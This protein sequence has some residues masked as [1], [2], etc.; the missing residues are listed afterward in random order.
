MDAY[1]E[2]RQQ[3]RVKRDK[4]IQAA[5]NECNVAL[6]RIAALQT[7]IADESRPAIGQP[8]RT[9][10]RS[11]TEILR[12]ALPKDKPFTVA[13]L[14]QVM[15]DSPATCKYKATS[16][17]SQFRV[18]D[19]GG[20]IRKVGRRNGQILWVRADAEIESSPFSALTLCEIAE[21]LI[22]EHGPL[23]VPEMVAYMRDRGYRPDQSGRY[24]GSLMRQALLRVNGR[25]VKDVS[26]RWMVANRA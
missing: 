25:F 21:Q 4:I 15:Y 18:L 23:R 3:A 19:Q 8:I 12:D 20:V 2:L 10:E 14:C 7:M 9:R 1:D 26:D 11:L 16:I 22:G 5:R 13:D 17:R 24:T 6:R